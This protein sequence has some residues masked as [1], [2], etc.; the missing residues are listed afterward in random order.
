MKICSANFVKTGHKAIFATHKSLSLL[1]IQSGFRHQCLPGRVK[2]WM[3]PFWICL[4][5][6]CVGF[7]WFCPVSTLRLKKLKTL[8]FNQLACCHFTIFSTV[9]KVK[10]YQK[11]RDLPKSTLCMNSWWLGTA[12]VSY[13]KA[14]ILV[15]VEMSSHLFFYKL[16]WAFLW[17][18]SAVPNHQEFMQRVDLGKSLFFFK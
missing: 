15:E 18:T 12:E 3:V 1:L 5:K 17:L 16:K 2:K 4:C 10:N 13:K 9:E 6:T 14:H 11:N 8:C 7:V